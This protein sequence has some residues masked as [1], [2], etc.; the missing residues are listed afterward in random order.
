METVINFIKS[1]LRRLWI[2]GY[3]EALIYDDNLKQTRT[4]TQR[5]IIWLG[6]VSLVIAVLAVYYFF[7]RHLV[8]SL[9]QR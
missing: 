3:N 8:S 9:L 1:F 7:F 6:I 4:L 5:I 2:L